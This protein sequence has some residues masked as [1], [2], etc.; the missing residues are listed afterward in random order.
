MIRI[1]NNISISDR[2]S[3]HIDVVAR[4][5]IEYT[6]TEDLIALF[7]DPDFAPGGWFVMS[8]GNNILFTQDVEQTI[9]T[10]TSQIITIVE[11]DD[12][13]ATIRVEGGVEWD[14]VV[15]W[16]VERDLWGIENLSL[17]PGK[18]C[19]APIQNIGAYG[20]EVCDVIESVDY[21]DPST[22]TTHTTEGR[23]CQ[24]GYRESIF[25]G[26]L[27]GRVIVTSIT[28]RLSKEPNPRLNYADVMARV[29]QRGGVSLRSIRDVIC[30]IRNEKLPDTSKLGNAGSFF[31]N[32]IVEREVAQVLKQSYPTMPIYNIE[33]DESRCKLAAGWLIDQAGLKGFRSGSVG[34]HDRQAL[35]LVN[36]G[37]ATGA[38]VVA[39]AHLVQQRIKAQFGVEI[40]CEVNIL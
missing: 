24:F 8:G 9:L 19:A 13:S 7:V 17:I 30:E 20:V 38:E 34:V 27:K 23:E 18:A 11:E 39:L 14:D 36:H 2:N 33:G 32:P 21:F 12:K 35:V 3:F 4:E 5:L 15:E 16:C 22:L 31:K 6:T 40:D 29:E 10:P 25:K 37:G 28:M 1:F 26:A